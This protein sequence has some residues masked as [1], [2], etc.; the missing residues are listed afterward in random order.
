MID[1]TGVGWRLWAV[2][3]CDAGVRLRNPWAGT[4]G[5]TWRRGE[6]HVAECIWRNRDA[7]SACLGLVSVSCTC[8]I[9]SM[10]TLP[11]LAG[12]LADG[13]Q[14]DGYDTTPL[15]VGR[16]RIGGRVQHRVGALEPHRGYQRSEFAQIDG[17]LLV[18]PSAAEHVQALVSCYGSARSPVFAPDLVAR[19]HGQQD[20]LEK[21]AVRAETLRSSAGPHGQS[22]VVQRPL[23]TSARA[24]RTSAR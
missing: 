21:L 5:G 18:S 11:D 3:E 20:W 14:L 13:R 4:A 22:R 24:G 2:E 12:F 9:R 10:A 17:P 7:S 6:V 1:W 16:V 23:V 8:G 19:A 15:V